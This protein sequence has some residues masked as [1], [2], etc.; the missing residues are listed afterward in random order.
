MVS[1]EQLY[2]FWDSKEQA[3]ILT[4][5]TVYVDS[6]MQGY[7]SGEVHHLGGCRVVRHHCGFAF[8]Y[9]I[10][11]AKDITQ[12]VY[13]MHTAKLEGG[14]F[15]L[16]CEN[17]NFCRYWQMNVGAKVEKR[18]FYELAQDKPCDIAVPDGFEIKPLDADII[19]QL[20]GRIVPSFF[21][22]ST[23]R[24]LN[25]G[26][27]FCVTENGEPAAWAFSAAVSDT[28]IDIGVETVERFRG[29]GLAAAVANE[30]V[31]YALSVGKKPVW[32]CHI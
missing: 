10:P 31:K 8:L 30:M 13:L 2:S 20:D 14:R 1:D 18:Y 24:F 22:D 15:V 27:G 4:C 7:Q 5:G 9:G 26:K 21:W 19:P 11:T 25:S 17:E 6:V 28:Q 32:A 12:T 29:N 23:Q 16:F 3:E